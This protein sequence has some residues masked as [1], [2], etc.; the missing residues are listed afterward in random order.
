MNEIMLSE[1]TPKQL[2]G[3]FPWTSKSE[4]AA[5]ML[6]EDAKDDH[7]IATACGVS[8]STLKRWKNDYQ[9]RARINEHISAYREKIRIT[10]IAVVENRISDLNAVRLKLKQIME[11]RAADP[12]MQNVPGGKTGLI[13]RQVKGIGKG[14]DFQMIELYSVDTG[15]ISS[16]C[17]VSRQASQELGQWS[18]RAQ[19]THTV[20]AYEMFDGFDE[21]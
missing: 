19:V 14:D 4:A 2:S 5:L 13:V 9:F 18:D 1:N 20:K 15:L 3:A 7:E 21:A 10:G 11:E 8:A 16:L 12:D 6:A 17:E